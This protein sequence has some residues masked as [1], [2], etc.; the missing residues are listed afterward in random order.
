M[1]EVIQSICRFVA[2]L[3]NVSLF[4]FMPNSSGTLSRA[5]TMP[6]PGGLKSYT[7]PMPC[8]KARFTVSYMHFV[9]FLFER[10][11][12]L[13]SDPEEKALIPW[14]KNET[15]WGKY[16]ENLSS[17]GKKHLLFNTDFLNIFYAPQASVCW[18]QLQAVY[19]SKVPANKRGLSPVLH[20]YS[21]FTTQQW[22]VFSRLLC[23]CSL[24]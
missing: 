16:S 1:W 5:I 2:S 10:G 19:I 17:V 12:V 7:F 20:A 23:P 13:Y 14:I 6:A 24:S 3:L 11:M 8:Q 22:N 15:K 18:T 4:K 21:H 9:S